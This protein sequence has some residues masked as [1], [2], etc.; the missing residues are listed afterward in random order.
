MIPTHIDMGL[1][2]NILKGVLIDADIDIWGFLGGASGTESACQ[3]RRLK[4]LYSLISI[5]GW[6]RS[7]GGG[8]VNPLQYSCWE[9]PMNR[10]AWQAW[11]RK[12]SGTTEHLSTQIQIYR[13]GAENNIFSLT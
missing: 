1:Y 4:R 3:C 7:P 8:N 6:E 12:E 2:T 9:N 5:P 13:L 10:G 11:G